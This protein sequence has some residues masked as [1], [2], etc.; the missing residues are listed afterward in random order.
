MDKTTTNLI[1]DLENIFKENLVS[2][3]L[4]GSAAFGE[5]HHGISD[6]NLMII[7]EK[8]SASDLKS[9]FPSIK[10]WK[11]TGNSLP[12]FMTKEE[13][14]N[15]CDTYPIEYSDIKERHRILYG[16]DFWDSLTINKPDLRLQC[17]TELR[18]I[19]LKLRQTYLENSNDKKSTENL[20]KR[21]STSIIAIFRAVLRLLDENIPAGHREV[22]DLLSTKI[23]FDKDIF[24]DIL[25]LREKKK[26]FLF[27]DSSI[28]IQKL[29]DSLDKITNYVDKI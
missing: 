8:L 21:S 11:K 2:V 18:N 13:I 25:L 10:K 26:N 15:S 20:I 22:L 28:I 4:Y 7:L 24:V 19:M 1:V 27:K 6:L 9:V 16:E 17:E 14:F 12:V 23:D 3:V 5:F 29:I